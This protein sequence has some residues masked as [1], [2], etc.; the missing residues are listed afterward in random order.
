MKIEA[1]KPFTAFDGQ[2]VVF[3][4]GDV[5]ELSDAVANQYV[6]AGLAR[7]TSK[8]VTEYDI[9]PDSVNEAEE[10]AMQEEVAPADD[11]WSDQAPA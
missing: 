11:A 3:N 6:E 4:T 2:M 10:P 1:I 8:K 7:K 9:G 5:R